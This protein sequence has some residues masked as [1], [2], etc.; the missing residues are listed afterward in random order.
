[1]PLTQAELLDIQADCLA[2]DVAID[3][4]KMSL[5]TMDQARIYFESG[6]EVEPMPAAPEFTA[7]STKGTRA[8][9]TTPWLAC[10]EKKDNSLY[11]IIVFSWTGNRGGQG[12]AHNLRRS[13]FNVSQELGADFEVY[14]VALPGRGTRLKEPLRTSMATLVQ[15]A[16]EALGSALADGKPYAFVGFSFGAILAYEVA[17]AIAAAAPGQGPALLC[18]VS[19]EGPSWPKRSGTL[20]SASED[21]FRQVLSDKGGTEFILK[22]PGMSKMYLPVIRADLTLEETYVPSK[23]AALAVPIIAVIGAKPGR[24]KEHSAVTADDAELWIDATSSK[25][26]SKV[27]VCG[28]VDWYVLQEAAGTRAVFEEVGTFLRACK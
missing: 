27:V 17:I 24:D 19:A 12:S 23:P 4:Q 3:L 10:L 8:T 26:A 22:D 20:H 1:M 16:A 7:P 9:G 28:E 14:E 11:R 6:G 15:E 18:T 2:D 21:A 25:A 5:W 13:P